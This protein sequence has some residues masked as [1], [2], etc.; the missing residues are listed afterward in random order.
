MSASKIVVCLQ[1]YYLVLSL[2]IGISYLSRAQESVAKDQT[3]NPLPSS[4][5]KP[6][7]S[8]SAHSV[9]DSMFV[10][11]IRSRIRNWKSACQDS[12]NKTDGEQDVGHCLLFWV[13]LNI[14]VLPIC[15]YWCCFFH[16]GRCLD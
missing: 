8:P 2:G 13:K 3:G 15:I 16:S 4:Y 5:I 12:E 7:Q 6:A 9:A 1:S 14:F 10:D 11:R